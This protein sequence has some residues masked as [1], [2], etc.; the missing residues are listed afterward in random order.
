MYAPGATMAISLS[1][2]LRDEPYDDL[3]CEAFFGG[4][5]PESDSVRNVIAKRYGISA[6]NTFSL[7]K[8][9]GY[10]CAGAISFHDVSDEVIAQNEIRFSGRI[11]TEKEL[12]SHIEDLPIRPLFIGLDGM[13]LSLAGAQNK[14]AVCIIE[15]EIALPE[16]G[17]PTTHILKPEVSH[18]EGMVENEYFCLR[19]ANRLGLSAP[20]VELRKTNQYKFLLIKRYD[21]LLKNNSVQRLHQEDFCQASGCLSTQ[22]YQNEGGPSFKDCF[23]LLE[24]VTQPAVDKDRLISVALFNYLIGNR[25]A[26]GKNFS[27]LYGKNNHIRL[28]PFYDLVC[29]GIYPDLTGKMAMKIG[30]QYDAEEIFPHDWKKF[31]ESI[32][33]SY[34]ELVKLL[35]KTS[36]QL[37]ASAYEER[38]EMEE[39]KISH[40]VL[41]K[42]IEFIEKNIKM[43]KRKLQ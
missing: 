18:F 7:L 43:V 17:C 32:H 37:I 25:D 11:V 23:S 28:A 19:L 40:P 29:T 3:I 8:A 1:M 24:Y 41:D 34:S 10:D 39:K 6:R 14:A 35:E 33:Y 26:H 13:R 16:N 9:I 12:A 31:C 5:L 4:L 30:S 42:I 38:R 36:S 15:N 2:P 22:K 21:R 20:E 27:L